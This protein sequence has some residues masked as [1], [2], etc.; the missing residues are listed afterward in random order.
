MKKILSALLLSSIFTA[1]AFAAEPTA[2][3]QTITQIKADYLADSGN[4]SKYLYQFSNSGCGG[5]WIES[6]DDNVNKLLYMA[7]LLQTPV[8]VGINGCSIIT[9]VVA[10]NTN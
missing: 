7:Y 9:T 4:E 2:F 3:N 6:A 1:S 10:S 5:S 8:D